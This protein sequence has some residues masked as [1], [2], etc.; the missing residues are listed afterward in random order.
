MQR[1]LGVA[2]L[3]Y[4]GDNNDTIQLMSPMFIDVTWGSIL[5]APAS[6]Q[7]FDLFVCPVYKPLKFVNWFQTY[8]VRTDPPKEYTRGQFREFLKL[9]AVER[10]V[11]YLHLADT[12]S[13]GRLGFEATQFHMFKA[14]NKFEVHGRHTGSANGLFMDGHTEACRK[15]RLEDLGIPGLFDRDGINGYYFP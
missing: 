1:Q 6:V 11:D 7:P 8:G 4:A 14:T 15:K 9:G 10:P 3:M 5:A 12:T 2:T 13:R